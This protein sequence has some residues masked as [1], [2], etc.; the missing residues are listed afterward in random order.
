MD[1]ALAWILH[2]RREI[3]PLRELASLSRWSAR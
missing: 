1:D 2:Q 3:G